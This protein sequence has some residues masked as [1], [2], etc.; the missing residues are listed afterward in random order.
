MLTRRQ[1]AGSLAAAAAAP[2]SAQTAPRLNVLLITNDQL[3]GDCLGA[4]GNRVI[5]TPNL[6]RLAAEGA[7]FE[8][9]FVQCPQCVPSRSAMHTGR[10]PHVN[11]TPSNLYRLPD[12][13]QTLATLLG[14]HGYTTAVCGELP[15]APTNFLGGFQK[16]VAGYTEYQASL[17]AEGYALKGVAHA[18][19]VKE[20]FQAVAAPW[21]DDVDESAFFAY[22]AIDFLT[23][24]KQSPFFL[25]VN[26][27]RPHHPFDPPKPFDT[28]YEG[29]A[30]PPSHRRDGEMKNKPPGQQRAL[31]NTVGFDLRTITSADLNRIKS[32]YF[33]MISENDKYIGKILDHLRD[34]GLADRTIV[35]FNADHGEM[36]G[37][38]GLVYKGGYMYDE[39]VRVP[40]ILRAP[41]K[42]E[43][44]KRVKA[45]A[46]EID[47]V[48]TV[49][50]LLGIEI[51]PA[52][53]GQDLL[54]PTKPRR[55]VHSEF[56]NIKML[57]SADW[58]LVHYLHA[59]Y[60]ELYN[61][62]EDPHELYNLYDDPGAAKPRHEME[63]E[64][65]DWLIDSQDPLLAPVQA[66]GH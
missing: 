45:L 34:T 21:P 56:S 40:L 60:G 7:I 38:H 62:R 9:Y 16:V 8:Q 2:A 19:A 5:R 12:T 17:L 20:N 1:F 39:V 11:R 44:G 61:L 36:L 28:M 51:P 50:R 57:R 14:R 29:A 63:S 54:N 47:L 31:E 10:Y 33:G 58:K 6:D 35:I 32:Y 13:E 23:A 59:P 65:A 55:S 18:A 43:A 52:V 3:R 26:Y 4:L 53:Q 64:L 41:G 24:H 66:E 46:E 27:R 48:P 25:H 49:L 42:I 15:F 37:D 30:F 22:K